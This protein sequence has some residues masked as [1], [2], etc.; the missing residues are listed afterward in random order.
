VI[1]PS[2]YPNPLAT[3]SSASVYF[4]LFQ[5]S[6]TQRNNLLYQHLL[7]TPRLLQRQK[8]SLCGF[9]L[10]ADL[11]QPLGICAQADM[12]F[13]LKLTDFRLTL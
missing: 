2:P 11:L 3:A 1:V 4:R 13:T 7:L 9:I 5:Q 10:R 6:L 12:D 8:L